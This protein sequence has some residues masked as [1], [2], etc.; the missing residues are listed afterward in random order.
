ML[1]RFILIWRTKIV[2]V[3]E[4]VVIQLRDLSIDYMYLFF[5]ELCLEIFRYIYKSNFPLFCCL[6]IFL[7]FSL[8]LIPFWIFLFI[9]RDHVLCTDELL[10]LFMSLYIVSS[11]KAQSTDLQPICTRV[12]GS[13]VLLVTPLKYPSILLWSYQYSYLEHLRINS[14]ISNIKFFTLQKETS[15]L[16]I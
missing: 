13:L 9:K 5:V 15:K 16:Q 12:R 11:K 1:K 4:Y 14:T 7:T 6:T 10:H 8:N 3:W 2:A